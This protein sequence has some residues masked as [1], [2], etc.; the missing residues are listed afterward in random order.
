MVGKGF[1]FGMLLQLAVG[2]MCLLVFQTAVTH[3]L[4]M[5]LLV[6]LAI[7]LVDLLFIILSGWGAAAVLKKPGVQRAVK[8]IGC[9]ILVLFGANTVAGAFGIS[10]LPQ[11]SLFSDVSGGSLF[12]QGLLLTAS[13]PLTILFWSGVFSTQIIEHQFTRIQLVQYGGGCVLSTLIF[14]SLVAVLG[15]VL[16]SFL[17][18]V[19]MQI[20]NAAVGLLL[21]F[22]GIRLLVKKDAPQAE[23]EASAVDSAPDTDGK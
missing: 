17:P 11:V 2:P 1:R 15:T 21:I 22:F 23:K 5:A 8:L 19:V 7:T 6:T 16:G 18:P 10:L 20:L 14:Q 9:I 3:G 12:L 4:W 13:N